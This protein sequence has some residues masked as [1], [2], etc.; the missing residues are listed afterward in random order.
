M[1][2]AVIILLLIAMVISL[3]SGAV[4]FFKD[5]GNSKRTL[6]ALGVRVTLAILLIICITYGVLSGQ[7]RLNAPW[8][9]GPT[10]QLTQ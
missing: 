4:F 9:Q 8:H 1:L 2:K 3:A 5:Q 10:S 6:H 7:L